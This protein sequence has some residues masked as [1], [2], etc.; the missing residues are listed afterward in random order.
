M[1]TSGSWLGSRTVTNGPQ[2]YLHWERI[3]TDI[4]NNRSKLR[5]TARIYSEYSISFSATKY[6]S[7]E[8][9][10]FSYTG[11]MSGSGYK[12]VK[13]KDIWV[14]HNSDGSKSVTLD[15]ELNINVSWSTGYVS[16]ISVSGTAYIDSIPRA[17]DLTSASIS[18]LTDGAS[19]TLSIGRDVKHSGFY[20]LLSLYD[21]NTWIWDSGYISGSPG[22]SYT[23]SSGYVN[24]MLNRMTTVTSKKFRI[25]L[26]TYSSS[27]GSGYIGES[28][29]DVTVSVNSAVKPSV[30]GLSR[31][32]TGN[33]VSSHYLQSIS[34]ISASFNASAGYGANLSETRI[35]IRRD[36]D[37][38][39]S[40]TISGMSGTTR[41]PI[42]LSGLYE[43]IAIATDSRGRTN[44]TRLTFTSTAYSPP[45][46]T[47]FSVKRQ[48]STPTIVDINRAGKH[49][50]LGGAN[51]LSVVIDK[52]VGSG[53]WTQAYSISFTTGS[54]GATVTEGS[55]D[56]AKSY[57]F[58]ITATDEFG[59][60]ATAFDTIS[61]QKV[62]FDKHKDLG[63]GIGKLHEKGVLDVDGEAYFKGNVFVNGVSLSNLV[64]FSSLDIV[65]EDTIDFWQSL[66]QGKYFV[67]TGQIPNQP[68]NYGILDH[69]TQGTGYGADFNSVWYSQS[70]GR[71]YRKSGNQNVLTD[72]I[73]VDVSSGSNSN[74]S[75]IRWGDGTQI[76]Q[77]EITLNTSDFGDV[78]IELPASFIDGNYSVFWS[79]VGHAYRSSRNMRALTMGIGSAYHRVRALKVHSIDFD[80]PG[81]DMN[82]L[83][84]AIGRW[85]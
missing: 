3:E 36:S 22:T 11:G 7:L 24:K 40:Q 70:S 5:L 78:Q 26:R 46:V 41:N 77:R 61:T 65:A 31:S 37:H 60:E 30:S 82:I 34:K 48:E 80:Y 56:V 6:G 23:L 4:T 67:S 2:L 47:D 50:D 38:K 58:R 62:L 39:D 63:I 73:M 9:S 81:H 1:A 14:N 57:E 42:S 71:I 45:E 79:D 75:W 29:R 12:T 32:Q 17:S 15:A 76:C 84:T 16:K 72:W 83:I 66:P 64:S 19:S 10:S 85:K 13:T 33:N 18:S 53:N 51:T 28:N 49:T 52:R 35:V 44:S 8:G 21:G 74:G 20:H 69:T 59:N 68:S 25:R 54:F 55:I 43:V 27:G